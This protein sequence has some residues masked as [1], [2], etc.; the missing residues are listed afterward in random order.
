[1]GIY[2]SSPV[3]PADPEAGPAQEAAA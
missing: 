2:T 1:V 3:S